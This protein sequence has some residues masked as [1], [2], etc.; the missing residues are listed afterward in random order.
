MKGKII[1]IIGVIYVILSV[2]VTKFLLDRNDYG[3]FET[4]DNYYVCDKVIEEYSKGS[5]VKFTKMD[6]YSALVNEKVYYFDEDKTLKSA[7]LVAYDKDEKIFTIGDINHSSDSL[8]G[9]P[10][11]GYALVGAII[12]F[13]TTKVF[14][15]LFIIIPVVFLLIYEIYLLTIYF[16]NGKNRKEANNEKMVGKN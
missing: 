12:S 10:T 3:A 16:R 9:K 7:E 14:Y 5:L 11:K 1:A 6:D 4:N 2:F 15:L 13:L 8:L